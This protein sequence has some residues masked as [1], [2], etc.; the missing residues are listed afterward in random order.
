VLFVR[1]GLD[2]EMAAAAVRHAHAAINHVRDDASALGLA[3]LVIPLVEHD[4]PIA[5]ELFEAALPLS[6]PCGIALIWQ[7]SVDVGSWHLREDRISG[8][9]VS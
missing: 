5:K 7:A 3:G 6:P 9:D 1:G 2:P 8:E 4:R